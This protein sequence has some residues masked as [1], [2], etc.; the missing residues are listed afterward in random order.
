VSDDPLW[1]KD[2]VF[3]EL[4]IKAFQDSNGDGIGDFKRAD[5]AARR[6][7][8]P[9]SIVSTLVNSVCSCRN[10]TRKSREPAGSC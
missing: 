9:M 2:A 10:A 3:Y 6:G 5:P 4:H 1:Y 8:E 7:A